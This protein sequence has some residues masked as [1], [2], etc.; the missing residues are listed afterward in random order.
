MMTSAPH[1]LPCV[2]PD[3]VT[4][5][6]TSCGRLDLL[7]RTLASFRHF[8]TGGRFILSED[9]V[10]AAVIARVKQMYPECL[11]LHDDERFGI[12]RSIDRLYSH[13]TTPYIFHLEDDWEFDGP[14]PWQALIDVLDHHPH[15]SNVCVRHFDEVKKKYRQ[16]SV[17]L[18]Q[19]GCAFRVMN[20]DAH[21]EFFSWSPN[22]GLISLALYQRYKP[23]AR[24]MPDQMSGVMKA[25]GLTM[26][27][28]VEGM[29][30]HIGHGR[31][32]TDPTMPERPTSYPAKW[33]RAFKKKLYYYGLRKEPF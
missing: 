33:L 27:Y 24:V 32:V 3:M 31:N 30:R 5:C 12:M 15:I 28:C 13:V 4:V 26:A 2:I 1:A 11:V 14:V 25:D 8:N 9:S 10:D 29:A 7:E 22:P 21:P 6:I 19:S 23:F 17:A 20:L 16:R 18:T